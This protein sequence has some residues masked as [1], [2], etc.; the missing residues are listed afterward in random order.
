VTA[1]RHVGLLL[2]LV[3]GLACGWRV[4]AQSDLLAGVIRGAAAWLGLVVLWMAGVSACERLVKKQMTD[5][6]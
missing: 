6:R 4:A 1:L 3:V 2:A 5:D